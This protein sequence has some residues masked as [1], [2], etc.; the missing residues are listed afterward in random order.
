MGLSFI[1]DKED[2]L[3]R[4]KKK[5]RLSYDSSTT[6]HST[7]FIIFIN[8]VELY[9]PFKLKSSDANILVDTISVTSNNSRNLV[10][11]GEFHVTEEDTI[12]VNVIRREW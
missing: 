7:C 3:E 11:K 9:E 2:Y 1:K 8:G 4:E 6:T 12:W 10:V 5:P